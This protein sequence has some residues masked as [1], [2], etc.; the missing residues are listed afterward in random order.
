MTKDRH[1]GDRYRP[2]V[3]IAKT[4]NGVPTVIDVSGHRYTLTH[5]HHNRG[6]QEINRRAK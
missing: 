6:A 4:K 3:T 5:P 2:V 1:K